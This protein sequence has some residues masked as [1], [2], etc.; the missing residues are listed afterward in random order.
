MLRS[1]PVGSFGAADSAPN[2]SF[3]R[4]RNEAPPVAGW[5]VHRERRDRAREVST[6]SFV[7]PADLGDEPVIDF[8]PVDVEGAST[9]GGADDPL[10]RPTGFDDDVL[11]IEEA[12]RGPG[13]A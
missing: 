13:H 10:A 4:R 11:L 12:L 7:A 8:H 6:S 2:R 5:A 3:E 1:Q 9:I